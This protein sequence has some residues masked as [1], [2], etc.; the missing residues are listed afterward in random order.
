M[1]DGCFQCHGTVGQGGR[2]T[3]PRIARTELPF[4]AF[5][6]QLRNPS[7]EMP[8]YEVKI[9]SNGDAAN[10]YAYLQSL[11]APLAVKDIPL[12]NQ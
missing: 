3:G 4:A 6:N 10:I 7:N 1:T 2:V 5:L 11:P 12:L 8:P 9:L